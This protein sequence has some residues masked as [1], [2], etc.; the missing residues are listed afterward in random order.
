M[1]SKILNVDGRQR[2]VFFARQDIAVGQE[3]TVR[4]GSCAGCWQGW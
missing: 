2:L 1:Y 4:G 3:L